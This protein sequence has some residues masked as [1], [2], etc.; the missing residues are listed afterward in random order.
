MPIDHP[1]ARPSHRG[2]TLLAALLLTLGATF[3]HA[4]EML[5]QRLETAAPPQVD[6]IVLQGGEELVDFYRGRDFRFAWFDA[7]GMQLR[8]EPVRQLMERIAAAPS[9]GLHADDYHLHELKNLLRGLDARSSTSLR[10]DLE[11]LLSDAALLYGSHLQAGKVAPGSV[12]AE[13]FADR[14]VMEIAPLL[15]AAVDQPDLGSGVGALLDR[16]P[17]AAPGYHRLRQARLMLLPL[18]RQWPHWA[19]IP[20]GPAIKPDAVDARLPAIAER[21]RLL[22]DAPATLIAGEQYDAELQQAVSHFQAR[23]GL[24]VDAVIGRGTLAALN[25]APAERLRQIDVALERW[26]WLPQTLGNRFVLVNIAGFELAVFDRGEIALRKRVVVGREYRRTPVFSDRIRYLE[27][28]PTWTVPNKLAVQDEL[29]KIRRDP[30]FLQRL[31]ITVYQGWGDN[32]RVVDPAGVD[33]QRVPTKPFPYYFV[34]Q[35]GPLNALG[36]IKFMF[37]NRFDVYL[38]DTPSRELFGRAE[39]SFS[40]GCVRVQDPLALATL[41]LGWDQGWTGAEVDAA[42]ASRERRVVT[43][44]SP[45]P[46]HIQY[47]TAWVERDGTVQFRRDIYKRDGALAT[48]LAAPLD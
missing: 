3:V 44:K 5:R 24:D 22:G 34:Q 36:Q 33:W 14:Q 37:P 47:A 15:T 26:R 9:H 25:V 13:W 40:S 32:R 35:P 29:P 7:S 42:I 43:L 31:G 45:I 1:Q 10:A 2:A 16:L 20:E 30:G 27:F 19:A 21:L 41:L 18:A 17:P 38:H 11:L 46:I 48:A 4:D 23:H 6:G 39:R 12:D 8:G 28:N